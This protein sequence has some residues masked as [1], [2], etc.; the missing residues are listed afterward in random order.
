MG[1]EHE[2]KGQIGPFP[3]PLELE[4]VQYEPYLAALFLVASAS[5]RVGAFLN[6][7]IL[8]KRAREILG[9]LGAS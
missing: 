5:L 8:D 4:G 1:P 9:I 2:L 7:R 3:E 6:G